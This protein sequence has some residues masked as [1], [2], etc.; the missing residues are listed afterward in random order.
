MWLAAS[1]CWPADHL[2]ALDHALRANSTLN[3]RA[4]LATPL[5]LSSR[6]ATGSRLM[7]PRSGLERSEFVPWPQPEVSTALPNVRC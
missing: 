2:D 1:G 5:L 6:L 4:D 7:P 3:D